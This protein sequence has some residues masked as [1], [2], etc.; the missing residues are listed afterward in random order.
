MNSGTQRRNRSRDVATR[1]AQPNWEISG[2]RV[3]GCGEQARASSGDGLDQRFCRRH[4]DFYARHGSPYKRSYT[5]TEL[6]PHRQKARHWL[7]ANPDHPMVTGALARVR[8]Y[9]QEAGP[10]IE[11]FRLRGLSPQAR[12][13]AAWARLRKANIDPVEILVA[14]LTIDAAIK[15]DPQPDHKREFKQVQAAR[16]VHRMASGTHKSWPAHGGGTQELHVYPRPRGRVLRHL[17]VDMETIG[18][19]LPQQDPD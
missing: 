9:F 1:A 15:S 19:L 3:V 10:H 13:K 16:L 14:W 17:G 12:A 4:A 5:A 2:C 8:R 18:D 6:K 7:A 11:A